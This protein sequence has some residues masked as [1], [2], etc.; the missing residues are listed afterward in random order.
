MSYDICSLPLPARFRP[1]GEMD[2]DAFLAF[3]RA[4][5]GLRIERE[6][7]GDIVVM[8]PA[9]GGSDR[10]GLFVARELD[11]WAEKDGRGVA[12]GSTAGFVLPDGSTLS[13]DAA[14]I[15]R[16]AW[17]QLT[18]ELREKFLPFC[19]AFVVEVLSSSDSLRRARDKMEQWMVN[20]AE[21][22]WLFDPYG[23]TVSIYRADG[24]G[25]EVLKEPDAVVAGEPVAG[26]RLTLRRVWE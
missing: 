23:K 16:S 9:G 19:P 11:C 22:G 10:R 26:F 3:C 20:G 12:F 2:D 7:S 18:P 25:V 13:P 1:D 21:L 5:D 6:R 15:R 4:N 8:S 14:W 24:S 17:D